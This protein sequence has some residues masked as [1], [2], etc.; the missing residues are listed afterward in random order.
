M[1]RPQPLVA[2]IALAA[3]FLSGGLGGGGTRLM[4]CTEADGTIHIESALNRCCDEEVA[5]GA[6]VGTLA[7]PAAAFTT[8]DGDCGSCVD[9]PIPGD[10]DGRAVVRSA[11][12]GSG[13]KLDAPA[14]AVFAPSMYVTNGVTGRFPATPIGAPSATAHLTVQTVVLRC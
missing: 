6:E 2:I 8:A 13:V 14:L 4:I 1:S 7:E 11:K 5:H 12:A 3:F 10:A 9:T